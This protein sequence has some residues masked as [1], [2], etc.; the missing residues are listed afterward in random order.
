MPT[1]EED[2]QY[3]AFIEGQAKTLRNLDFTGDEVLW[4]YTTGDALLSI[5]DSGT[6]YATQISCL[7]DSTELRYGI[8][9]LREALMTTQTMSSLHTDQEDVP[10][11]LEQNQLLEKLLIATTGA[12]QPAA[13]PAIGSAW[14]VSCFSTQRDDLSQWRAYGLKENG[15][16]IGFQA[17]GFFGPGNIVLRV[18]YN[19]DDQKKAAVEVATATLRFF[20]EGLF[21]RADVTWETWGVE[22]LTRWGFWLGRL[23]PMLKNPAFSGEKEF[24]IIHELQTNERGKLRFKQKQ[25][26][27]SRHLPL[28]FPPTEGAAG[29]LPIV[30]VIVGPSRH[31]ELSRASVEEF[32]RQKGYRVP[33]TTSMVP[34]QET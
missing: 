4:H 34:Y 24:R 2:K 15:Y 31:K 11:T 10:L 25:S 3:L 20:Q 29:M 13:Q 28:A 22:F 14:F 6:V 30:E 27:M 16:A 17:R 21:A 12:D 1:I 32:M 26:L 9:L 33:V 8:Q 18:N 23:A 7:N 5:V 19:E